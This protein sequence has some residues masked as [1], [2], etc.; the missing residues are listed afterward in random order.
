[1]GSIY[2]AVVLPELLTDEQ[3]ES[4]LGWLTDAVANK[5]AQETPRHASSLPSQSIY[6]NCGEGWACAFNL[7][8]E[9]VAV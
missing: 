9:G 2:S 6:I 7:A 5:S 1:M 4:A 3:L 8:P